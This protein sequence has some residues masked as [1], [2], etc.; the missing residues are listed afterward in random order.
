MERAKAGFS[1]IRAIE[2][3]LPEQA[4]TTEG[5]ASEFPEWSVE[6]IAAKTGIDVRWVA[7]VEQTAGDLAH[8]AARK[9]FSTGACRPQDVDYLLLCTQSPDYFL[10]TTA[11]ILQDRLGI[12]TSAGALDFNLG[13]SGYIYGLGLA[14]GLVATGQASR[15]LLLTSDTYTKYLNRGDKSVRTIFGDAAAATLIVPAAEGAGLGP[16]HY[17]TDGSGAPNLMVPTGGFR[18][19]RTK[20]SAVEYADEYGNTRSG[21]NLYMNG[22]EIFGFTLRAV[23][24]AIDQLLAKAGLRGDEVDFYVFHQA[25]RYMLDHLRKSMKIPAEKFVVQ[26]SECGNTVS[27]TIPIA[28]KRMGEI[29]AG[30]RVVLVGFGV[31]YS[32]GAALWRT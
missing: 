20:E 14:E 23:P 21:D 2:Y 30:K 8:E 28:L 3:Y 9:L 16:F 11:C 12:P 31:G 22:P 5:L 10:P 19:P 4:L 26:M 18:A 7:G 6:K 29:G 1:T 15:V 17:G 24:A 32:W 27:S 13:C 25:N